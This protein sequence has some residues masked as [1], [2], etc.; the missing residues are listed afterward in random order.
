MDKHYN[1]ETGMMRDSQLDQ[2][3]GGMKEV[4]GKV[5]MSAGDLTGNEKMRAKG[6]EKQT[7]GKAQNMWGKA[8]EAVADAT[9]TVGDALNPNSGD[10]ALNRDYR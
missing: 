8:K 9:E 7:E 10:P 3:N 4:A 1:D 5:E 2:A 6:A